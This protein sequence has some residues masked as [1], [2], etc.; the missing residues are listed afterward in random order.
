M[1]KNKKLLKAF[2]VV[3][4]KSKPKMKA[5]NSKK[6]SDKVCLLPSSL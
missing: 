4:N 1:A 5:Q 3:N 6:G 2:K